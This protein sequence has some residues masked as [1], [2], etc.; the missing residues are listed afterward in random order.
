M[1]IISES[2]YPLESSE[3]IVKRISEMPPLPD[4][5][6]LKG[7]YARFILKSRIKSISI[8]EFGDLE[9]AKA[10]EYITNR[11]SSCDDVTGFTYNVR[12]WY[13]EQKLVSL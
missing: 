4:F 3:E 12:I 9:F 7:P 2:L 8:Y 5:I 6:S 11:I 1:V 10:F 13:E